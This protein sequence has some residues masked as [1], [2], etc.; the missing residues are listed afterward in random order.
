VKGGGF[1]LAVLIQI[2]DGAPE[3]VEVDGKLIEA[4]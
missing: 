2:S 4:E 3:P 1:Q